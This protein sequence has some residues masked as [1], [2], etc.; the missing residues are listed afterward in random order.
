M[1]L[2]VPLPEATAYVRSEV[3]ADSGEIEAA[4]LTACQDIDA[5]TQRNFAVPTTETTV[6]YAP[7]FGASLLKVRDIANTTGLVISNDGS[8]VAAADYQLEVAPG[9]TSAINGESVPYSYV[10]L[11]GGAWWTYDDMRATV[12]ITARHGWPATPAAV[13]LAAKMLTR[14]LVKARATSFGVQAF[15]DGFTR[16]ITENA[17]VMQL[18]APY[19]AV[20]AVGIA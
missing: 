9:R 5:Y 16:R 13:E 4:L 3:S 7:S 10:R 18:L 17:M 20:E 12:S 6:T 14:D 2:Y 15:A 8:T 1:T 19:R 11:L